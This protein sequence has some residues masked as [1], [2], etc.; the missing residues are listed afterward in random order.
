MKTHHNVPRTT[1]LALC[2][3]GLLT[4]AACNRSDPVLDRPAAVN[5]PSVAM[6]PAPNTSNMPMTSSNPMAPTDRD[7]TSQ[8]EDSL[9]KD[10]TLSSQS[11]DVDT[12]D[13][14]VRLRGT[15]DTQAQRDQALV[16]VRAVTGVREVQD[17]LTFKR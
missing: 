3:A 4:L 6:A 9:S 14:Q 11:I 2:A 5:S 10:Y 8:V 15:V 16:V 13:G 1:V 17:E 12:T 7:I